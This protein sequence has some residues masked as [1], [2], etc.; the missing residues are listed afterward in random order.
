MP[1][2]TSASLGIPQ[3]R[4]QSRGPR[5]SPSTTRRSSISR[6]R[7]TVTILHIRTSRFQTVPPTT[8]AGPSSSPGTALRSL[9][10]ALSSGCDSR[11]ATATFSRSHSIRW[12]KDEAGAWQKTG[13]RLYAHRIVDGNGHLSHR[14]RSSVHITQRL[15]ATIPD[16]IP[17]LEF[18]SGSETR[19]G[20]DRA[21]RER[22]WLSAADLL[23]QCCSRKFRNLS[24]RLEPG[25][26]Y[27]HQALRKYVRDRHRGCRRGHHARRFRPPPRDQTP[28]PKQSHPPLDSLP[29]TRHAPHPGPRPQNL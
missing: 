8:F 16:G 3:L 17:G 26:S 28:T 7:S 27:S 6:A 22:C 1:R 14:L 13:T 2:G 23:F 24:F 18:F 5:C 29:I 9:V 25:L 10:N 19:I 11:A 20:P 4:I 21:R 12:W 15:A